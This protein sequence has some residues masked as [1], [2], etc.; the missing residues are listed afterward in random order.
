MTNSG[1]RHQKGPLESL[2]FGTFQ[3]LVFQSICAFP[4]HILSMTLVDFGAEYR[5]SYALNRKQCPLQT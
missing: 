1:S 5:Y 4:M 2:Q 3:E